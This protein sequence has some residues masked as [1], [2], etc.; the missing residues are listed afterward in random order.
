MDIGNVKRQSS[1]GVK[2]DQNTKKKDMAE[3]EAYNFITINK[4]IFKVYSAYDELPHYM[5][6]NTELLS[7]EIDYEIVV[8][9][10]LITNMIRIDSDI[11]IPASTVRGNI[12]TNLQILGFTALDCD[13]EDQRFRYRS[14]FNSP[15]A[16]VYAEKAG[17]VCQQKNGNWTKKSY[18]NI[19][20][21]IMKCEDGKYYIQKCDNIFMKKENKGG[22]LEPYNG[23]YAIDLRKLSNMEAWK[24]RFQVR[25]KNYVNIFSSLSSGMYSSRRASASRS[26]TIRIPFMLPVLFTTDRNMALTSVKNHDSADKKAYIDKNIQEGYLLSSGFVPGNKK[27]YLIPRTSIDNERYL[28]KECVIK[29]YIKNTS[30]Y[31]NIQDEQRYYQLPQNGEE[32]PV[33]YIQNAEEIQ[34]GFTLLFPFFYKNS[35]KEGIRQNTLSKG[36][37]YDE[38]IFGF[39]K[40]E[41]TYAGRVSF[42]NVYLSEGKVEKNSVPVMYVPKAQC[43][44]NYIE[45]NTG[46]AYE[47]PDF[48]LRGLKQYWLHRDVYQ[49][50]LKEEHTK[51]MDMARAGSVFLGKIRFY[52]LRPD[53]LGLL[54]WSL[55]LNQNSEQ[56]WGYAKPLGYGRIKLKIRHAYLY[57]QDNF[58][59]HTEAFSD[60]RREFHPIEYIQKYITVLEDFLGLDKEFYVSLGRREE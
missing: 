12:R 55:E 19:Y 50:S 23:Y 59:M 56:N 37:D 4:D 51:S 27:I 6:I 31:S 42:E 25:Y 30:S 8:K 33:F 22:G 16:K 13:I 7:G 43:A 15:L 60:T 52:N 5:D 41:E 9:T 38:A 2:S 20:A 32:K 10:A 28:I 49:G 34:F 18:T 46:L 58:M 35:V 54:L 45:E 11:S 14:F 48:T 1:I 21:G 24:T 26:K 57:Q 36:Y 3:T 44:L 47:N 17:T 39:K 40:K 29:D 53:E